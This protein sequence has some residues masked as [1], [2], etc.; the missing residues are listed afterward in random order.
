MVLSQLPVARIPD[1]AST[2]PTALIGASCWATWV[3]WPQFASNMR[4]ALSAPPENI[5]FPSCIQRPRWFNVDE[6]WRFQVEPY[7][8]PTYIQNWTLV[9]IHCF[10]LAL[11]SSTYFVN[12]YLET[13]IPL[14][15]QIACFETYA[16][17]PAPYCHVVCLTRK[18]YG[19]YGI[20]WRIGYFDIFI[21]RWRSIDWGTNTGC[22]TEKHHFKD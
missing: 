19:G 12:S 2:Q 4:P 17:I 9:L 11:S 18:R 15:N 10:T 8:I 3:A 22:I 5:L 20:S 6:E 13:E 14:I 7:L 16:V 21:W 1:W